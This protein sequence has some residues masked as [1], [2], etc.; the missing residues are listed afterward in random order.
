MDSRLQPAGVTGGVTASFIRAYS[1]L[2]T[3]QSKS[4]TTAFICNKKGLVIVLT[5][6]FYFCTPGGNRTPN[7]QIRSLLLYPLSYWG[8]TSVILILYGNDVNIVSPSPLVTTDGISVIVGGIIA[9]EVVVGEGGN[10]RF[11][12]MY[13]IL[14]HQSR[15]G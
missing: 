10:G 14:C 12:R 11:H 4:C 2:K 7:L 13:C 8:N 3:A 1:I 6:P 9:P 15:I 5:N